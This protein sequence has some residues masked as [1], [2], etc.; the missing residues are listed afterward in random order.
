MDPVVEQTGQIW[1]LDGP[2]VRSAQRWNCPARKM[3]PR[4]KARNRILRALLNMWLLKMK[5][6]QEWLRGQ[7]LLAPGVR[8]SNGH[9][10]LPDRLN[11]QEMQRCNLPWLDAVAR[12]AL[13]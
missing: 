12:R 7:G 1:E 2:E 3:T 9:A 5:L 6:R 10:D 8:W 13:Q 11:Y 4:S